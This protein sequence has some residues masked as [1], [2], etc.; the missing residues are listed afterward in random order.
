MLEASVTLHDLRVRIPD[1]P[2]CRAACLAWSLVHSGLS[3]QSA[4]LKSKVERHRQQLKGTTPHTPTLVQT[5]EGKNQL[6]P[7]L[8]PAWLEASGLQRA[9][10]LLTYTLSPFPALHKH[11]LLGVFGLLGVSVLLT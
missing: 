2:S 4:E 1:I 9:C 10:F 8:S 11:A 5:T 3:V 6:F 7:P